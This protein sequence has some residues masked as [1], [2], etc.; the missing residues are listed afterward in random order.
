MGLRLFPTKNISVD[1]AI[2]SCHLLEMQFTSCGILLTISSDPQP[3]SPSSLLPSFQSMLTLV[4]FA[5]EPL[6]ERLGIYVHITNSNQRLLKCVR[7]KDYRVLFIWRPSVDEHCRWYTCLHS[8]WWSYR[9]TVTGT[10]FGIETINAKRN[11]SFQCKH[12]HIIAQILFS[13]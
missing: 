3:Q 9:L 1:T 5:M 10:V 11:V 7:R 4:R 6:R 13:W 2:S 12:M 8:N